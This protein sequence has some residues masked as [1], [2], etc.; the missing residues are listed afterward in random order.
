MLISIFLKADDLC[1][2]LEK[3]LINKWLS[4]GKNICD[5][6]KK[7]NLFDSEI[8]TILIFYHYSGFKNFEYYYKQLLENELREYFPK[9]VSYTRFLELIETVALQMFIFSKS[10]RNGSDCLI[11]YRAASSQFRVSAFQILESSFL[12][13]LSEIGAIVVLDNKFIPAGA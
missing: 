2:Y 10:L 11:S 4:D 9:L 5:Y 7:S 8:M 3:E 12:T 6:K 1:K 13:S